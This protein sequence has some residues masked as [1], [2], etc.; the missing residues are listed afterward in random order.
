MRQPPREVFAHTSTLDGLD[1]QRLT[2]ALRE[3]YGS[4]F[5]SGKGCC[6]RTR[7]RNQPQSFECAVRR[8][9]L[10]SPIARVGDVHPSRARVDGDAFGADELTRTR[11]VCS[12]RG[13][14]MP[15]R[16]KLDDAIATVV[17]HPQVP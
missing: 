13:K 5:W 17:C 12:P 4:D 16:R 8:E 15:V 1:Y 6:C 14:E 10:H 3:H 7:L 2:L 11:A 9:A